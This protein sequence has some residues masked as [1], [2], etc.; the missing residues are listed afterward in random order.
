MIKLTKNSETKPAEAAKPSANPPV[1]FSVEE[2][3]KAVA[4][5]VA[6]ALEKQKTKIDAAVTAMNGKSD[7]SVKAEIQCVRAFKRAGFGIVRPHE[8]VRTFNKW[9]L[10]GYRPKEGTKAVKVGAFRLFHRSQLRKLTAEEKTKLAEDNAAAIARYAS[11][12]TVV[13]LNNPQ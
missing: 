3:N 5:A 1:T 8:D 12:A 2:M 6:E 9:A 4:A 11:R 10:D 7:G 13:P